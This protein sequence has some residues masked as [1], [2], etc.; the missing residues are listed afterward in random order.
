MSEV[1]PAAVSGL[2]YPAETKTLQ[3]TV[4]DLLTTARTDAPAAKA[5]VAPHAGYV[6]SGTVAATVYARL[7]NRDHPIERVVLLG[8]DHRVGFA[9]IAAPDAAYYETPLGRVPVDQEAMQPLLARGQIAVFAPAHAQE[10]SL[11]V[12]LPFLQTVLPRFRLIPLVVGHIDPAQVAAVIDALFG[13]DQTL[14]IVSSDLSHFH[15]YAEAQRL[16]Q[17]TSAAIEALNDA[18]I[19]P[20]EA[21]GAIPLRGLLQV[22]KRRGLGAKTVALCNSG[23]VGADRQRVVGYGAYVF[24]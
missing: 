21:C 19:G 6:Y 16:D 7:E 10:H 24:H 15:P 20:H 22:A 12:H 5:C 1:R 11:E 18:V 13:D 17:E 8:P 23:D 9:G 14:I 4:D 3:R 2:F